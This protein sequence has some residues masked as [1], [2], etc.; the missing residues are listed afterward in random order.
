MDKN[1]SLTISVSMKD[2][3]YFQRM[4]EMLSKA[5]TDERIP[6]KIRQEYFDEINMTFELSEQAP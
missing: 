4:L 6:K 1:K 5:I 2:T 3:W